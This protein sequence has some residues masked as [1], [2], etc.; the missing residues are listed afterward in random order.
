MVNRST[1]LNV[2][3]E[4][5]N[6][7]H[8]RGD[9]FDT[10][11]ELVGL[12]DYYAANNNHI[13]RFI[14]SELKVTGNKSG[15]IKITDLLQPFD[16]YMSS[17]GEVKRPDHVKDKLEDEL[18][19]TRGCIV[20]LG[21]GNVKTV[22]GIRIKNAADRAADSKKERNE[23]EKAE[24]TSSEILDRFFYNY[25][26]HD[27]ESVTPISAVDMALSNYLMTYYEGVRLEKIWSDIYGESFYA[28]Y[29][30]EDC[31]LEY[32]AKHEADLPYTY[33]GYG[34][35][36][37]DVATPFGK[38]YSC[39]ALDGLRLATPD[40]IEESEKQRKYQAVES[41]IKAEMQIGI[42][43][44]IYKALMDDETVV[45]KLAEI[46]AVYADSIAIA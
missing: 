15:A 19:Q 17:I 16:D 44:E 6:R 7:Y 37:L 25:C 41:E 39:M 42:R 32:F 3:I 26:I 29:G 20:K 28:Q 23:R 36:S 4:G 5:Y 40:E 31:L 10:P 46:I 35:T 33:D 22:Y 30:D 14:S 38:S 24:I 11:V 12:L 1:M 18:Q 43:P 34:I 8:A 45:A 9:K 27:S 2:L 21:S 13:R